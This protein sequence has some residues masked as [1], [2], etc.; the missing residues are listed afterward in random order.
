MKGNDHI[1]DTHFFSTSIH[2]DMGGRVLKMTLVLFRHFF[3][4]NPSNNKDDLH[5]FIPIVVA[6]G[7][8]GSLQTCHDDRCKAA[9]FL[10]NL[11]SLEARNLVLLFVLLLFFL[12]LKNMAKAFF[13]FLVNHLL[14]CL[15][16]TQTI[17]FF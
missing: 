9:G 2:E 17:D 11:A 4:T 15:Y 1:G 3:E 8:L 5:C 13:D 16:L 6:L 14:A 10:K 12:F 7:P